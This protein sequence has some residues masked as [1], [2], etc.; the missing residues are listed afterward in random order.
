MFVTPCRSLPRV[1]RNVEPR[2]GTTS[3]GLV[4]PGA[5]RIDPCRVGGEARGRRG[6]R[7][8]GNCR[9]GRR[10]RATPPESPGRWRRDPAWTGERSNPERGVRATA[11]GARRRR[12][13]PPTA[14]A[15]RGRGRTRRFLLRH[16]L[17]RGDGKRRAAS[18]KLPGRCRRFRTLTVA[19]EKA[20]LVYSPK[21]ESRARN[22]AADAVGSASAAER[23]REMRSESVR[24]R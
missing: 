20:R 22:R 9:D 5:R 14:H 4:V 6:T 8:L 1:K 24:R 15:L 19:R 16:R 3:G 13:S 21:S 12:P 17:R 10:R 23:R 11:R 2:L 7:E 18:A